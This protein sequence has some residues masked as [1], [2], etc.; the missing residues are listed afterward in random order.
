MPVVGGVRG[1]DFEEGEVD[2]D[3]VGVVE[4]VRV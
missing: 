3:S 4:A 1:G 2:G